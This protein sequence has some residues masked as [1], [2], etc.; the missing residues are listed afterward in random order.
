VQQALA[1]DPS[2]PEALYYEGIIE[3]QGLHRADLARKAFQAYLRAA[4][5]GS[6][7]GE[8]RQYLG[9]ARSPSPSGT[10]TS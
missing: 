1:V 6:H 8:V 4:P 10:P 7:V 3:L 5:F 2:Y 9:Q